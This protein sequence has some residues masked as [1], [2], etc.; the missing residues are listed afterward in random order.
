M[1]LLNISISF[2]GLVIVMVTWLMYL[3]T[4][5]R[6]KVPVNPIGAKILQGTGICLGASSSILDGLA[7]NHRAL[8]CLFRP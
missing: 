8:S 4:I 5:P 7:A 1:S 3:R 2:S 6:M